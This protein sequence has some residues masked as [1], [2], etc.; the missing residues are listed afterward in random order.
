METME[1]YL[2][3]C[4]YQT[5]KLEL[6]KEAVFFQNYAAGYE[7]TEKSRSFTSVSLEEDEKM[8]RN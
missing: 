2:A 7:T 3:K 1:E 8:E 6:A 5:K 4:D